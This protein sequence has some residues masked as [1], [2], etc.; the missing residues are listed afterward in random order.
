MNNQQKQKIK[1]LRAEGLSYSKISAALGISENTIKSFCKRN[2]LGGRG[3]APSGETEIKPGGCKNCGKE[4]VQTFKHKTR[5]FC[6]DECRVQ[7]WNSHLEMVHKKAIYTYKCPNCGKSFT[8]YGNSKRKFCC[9]ECY[10]KFRFKGGNG[11]ADKT[12]V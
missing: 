2:A 10:I 12:A 3:N 9:H 5:K 4:L 6:C 7:W 11:N 1:E 8:A